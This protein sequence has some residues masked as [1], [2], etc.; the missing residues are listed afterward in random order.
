MNCQYQLSDGLCD[1]PIRKDKKSYSGWTHTHGF[2]WLHW[3]S[4]ISYGQGLKETE[5]I[6]ALCIH[7]GKSGPEN[8]AHVMKKDHGGHRFEAK[9]K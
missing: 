4:P 2:D 8:Q 5:R 9:I 3:A 6:M 7:C 1:A